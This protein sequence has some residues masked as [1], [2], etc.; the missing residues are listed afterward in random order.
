MLVNEME[1]S[2][3]ETAYL[4]IT[5]EELN[6]DERLR[7]QLWDSDRFNADDDL[8]RIEL[9]LKQLMKDHETNGRMA[10]RTDGFKALKAGEDM[11]GKLVWSLGYFSKTRIQ[12]C[13]LEKQTFDPD[14]HSMEELEK[15][16]N[17]TCEHKLREALVKEGSGSRDDSELEM[18]KAQEMKHRQDAMMISAPPPDG[19]PSGIFSIQIHQITGLELQKLNKK[20]HAHDD[21]DDDE[22][23]T[24]DGVPSSYCNVIINHSRVFKTRTKPKSAKPFFNAGVE[25]FIPDWRSA[26][27][28]VT[29]RDMRLKE[30]DPLLGIVHLPLGEVFKKRSQISSF[31]PLMGG[32]GFGR[33]RLSM[34]WRSVQ[35]QA[36]PQALGWEYGTL[37][38]KSGVPMSDIPD[39][40]KDKKLTF[41]T[42]ISRGKMYAEKEEARWSSR[43]QT[44]L[45][46]AVRKRYSS[47][48]A[49]EFRTH[50]RLLNKERAFAILWLRDISDEEE[51]Q[52]TLP[53]WKGDYDRATKCSLEECGDK[54]GSITVT[55]TFWSGLGGAHSKWASKDPNVRDIV[56]VLDTAH[57]N[58]VSL[59]LE[60]VVCDIY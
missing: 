37:E 34:V 42:T 31:Y 22:Q 23:E 4:L 6:V 44:S 16:V 13:Q 24:G 32:V 46:L 45:K 58:Y 17:D 3:N 12:S 8:G 41:H 18:Q 2:W 50:G 48:L 53:V 47:C 38:V 11:P 59:E 35:L 1:P 36:P 52:L 29:V 27:V 49:I 40:L 21:E 51:C 5:A 25:R 30:D 54:V 15:K 19:Y 28:Y 57:D 43:K 26:E 9:D 20:E 33:I 10:E 14:V 56:E 39:D 55:C 7:V 60:V